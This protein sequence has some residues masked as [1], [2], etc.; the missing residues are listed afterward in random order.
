MSARPADGQ[1]CEVAGQR[2]RLSVNR[3]ARRVSIRIDAARGEAVAVAPS[4]R[5]LADAL[6][7]ARERAGWIR[8]RLAARPAGQAFRPGGTAPLEGR[9]IPLQA[10]PGAA[11]ARLLDTPDG[12]VIRSGGEGEAFARRVESLLKRMARERLTHHTRAHAEALGLRCPTVAIGD[13][14]SRWGSCTPGRGSIRYSWRLILAPP[15]VL[16]YVAAHEVAHL[17]HADHSPNFWAVVRRLVGD[18]RPHRAWLRANGAA[19]HGAGR[20]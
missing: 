17:V 4:D 1:V 12:L 8:E 9:A 6:A 19:L 18:E 3:R 5:R 2:V 11:A 20:P 16:D 15:E 13:P 7:F 14:K 10:A